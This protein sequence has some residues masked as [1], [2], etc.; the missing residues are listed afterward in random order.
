M[1]GLLD[2][3]GLLNAYEFGYF[4]LLSDW[5]LGAFRYFVYL[6]DWVIG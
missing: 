4:G 1:I 5:V 6:G 3:F 2:N